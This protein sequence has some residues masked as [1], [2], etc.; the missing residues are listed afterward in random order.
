MLDSRLIPSRLVDP[1]ERVGVRIAPPQKPARWR[2]RH[3]MSVLFQL[4][5]LAAEIILLHLRGRLKGRDAGRIVRERLEKLGALWIR[6]GRI[7]ALRIDIFGLDFCEE[8]DRI[9]DRA[10]GVPWK[11]IQCILEEEL[12]RPLETYFDEF[13]QTPF[14]ATTISQIHMAHLRRED[15]W[16]AVNIQRPSPP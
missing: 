1:S 13:Q 14:V 9:Q 11:S 12:G 16:V 4:G 2:W 5:K 10:D 3:T 15:V 6:V 8:L 7:V